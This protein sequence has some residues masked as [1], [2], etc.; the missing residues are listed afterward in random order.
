M[1]NVWL[2]TFSQRNLMHSLLVKKGNI[3]IFYYF[4]SQ[5][6]GP[7][8][9]YRRSVLIQWG[10]W[11]VSQVLVI[12]SFLKIQPLRA[13]DGAD[14]PH[15]HP[16]F[17]GKC[18]PVRRC[19]LWLPSARSASSPWEGRSSREVQVSLLPAHTPQ[20]KSV[21]EKPALKT[22][23]QPSKS[24]VLGTKHLTNSTMK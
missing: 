20:V 23:Q 7:I 2:S 14:S 9:S 19:C 6:M 4:L 8:I 22:D 16:R 18:P 10:Y 12:L 5:N 13:S 21:I 1:E 11:F 17:L 24:C 3:F 15:P